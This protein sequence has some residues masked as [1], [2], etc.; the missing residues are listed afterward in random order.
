MRAQL[1]FSAACLAAAALLFGGAAQARPQVPSD[2]RYIPYQTRL[3]LC[4]DAEVLSTVQSRFSQRESYYW[5]SG[6]EIVAFERVGESRLPRAG[7]DTIPRRYC[8]GRAV[9]NDQKVRSIVYWIGEELNMAG[10]DIVHSLSQS[11]TFGFFPGFNATSQVNWGIEFCVVGL[12]RSYTH[13]L[14]C[15]AARP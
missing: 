7:L 8:E 9:M 3:P 1:A 2:Q 4:G 12:D 11:L 13:S 6:L 10:G 15:R 5:K 14:N